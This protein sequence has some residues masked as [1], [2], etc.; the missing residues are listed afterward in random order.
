MNKTTLTS[1]ATGDTSNSNFG[2]KIPQWSEA[3]SSEEGDV[4]MRKCKR[5]GNVEIK[6]GKVKGSSGEVEEIK[7]RKCKSKSHVFIIN[8]KIKEIGS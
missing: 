7:I 3:S 8:D 4:G 1:Q 6:N 2:A 5:K